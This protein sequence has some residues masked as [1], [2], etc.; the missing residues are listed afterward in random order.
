MP[1]NPKHYLARLAFT[2]VELLVTIAIIGIL[3]A[4]LFPAVQSVREAA[5]RTHCQNNL[6]QIGLAI[7]NYES[8]FKR[9]PPG[10]I[11]CDDSGEMMLIKNCPAGSSAAQKNGASGFVS[12]L[13]FVEQQGLFSKLDVAN[14][15]L[16]NRDVDDLDW[17]WSDP[18]KN[19]GVKQELSIYWC[20]S[21][22]S[23]RRSSV[24]EPVWAATSSYALSS[25]TL[26]PSSADYEVKYFNDGA[27]VYRTPKHLRDIHDGLSNTF[28]IGEVVSPDIWESSNIWNYAIANADCLRST[29]NPLNTPPGDGT[30]NMLRNGAFASNHPQSG[31]FL[32]LDGHVKVLSDRIGLVAYRSMSTIRHGELIE[33]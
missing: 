32:Y 13:P 21:E 19:W 12:I 26:G 24:Y 30:V 25:G 20:P 22:V 18:D 15:G 5:R 6:R 23:S 17:Y 2:V 3:V 8:T 16:W 14:G 27:F 7:A 31:L 1:G 33:N 29:E 11:G 9:L 4:I 10:R 28:A